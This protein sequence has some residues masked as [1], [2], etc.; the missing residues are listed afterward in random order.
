MKTIALLTRRM[1]NGGIERVV[2]LLIPILNQAGY[3]TVLLTSDPA[4]KEDYPVPE[5]TKR[6]VI[7]VDGEERQ[8]KLSEILIRER[9]DVLFCHDYSGF[10]LEDD[11]KTAKKKD[12]RTLITWHNV[13]TALFVENDEFFI[14][15]IIAALSADMILTLSRTDEYFFKCCGANAKYIQ[16]PLPFQIKRQRS[17]SSAKDSPIILFPARI[18]PEKNPLD[19]IRIFAEVHKVIP[20]AIM[21]IAGADKFPDLDAK[22]TA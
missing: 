20:Q 10:T 15:K 1:Y 9:V 21:K 3:E 16:N 12:I 17:R 7:P 13:F 19:A 6:F 22:I 11:L 2:S 8:E 14:K 5:T 4:R 18:S